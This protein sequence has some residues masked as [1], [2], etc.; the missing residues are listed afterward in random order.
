VECNN[1]CPF[2]VWS[3]YH[4]GCH[5]TNRQL[6]KPKLKGYYSK[7]TNAKYLIGCALFA[8]LLT[9]CSILSMAMQSDD[10]YILAVLSSFLKSVKEIDKL[11]SSSLERWPLYAATL[12]K[13]SE[14]DDTVAYQSQKLKGFLEA[15]R[16]FESMYKAY[17]TK[18]SDCLKSRLSCSDLQM[19]RDIVL[20]LAT[21][22]LDKDDT[23]I[24]LIGLLI[25]FHTL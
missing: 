16:Y 25:I 18:V 7:W 14:T 17:C 15:K 6:T 20:V 22:D 10:F 11:S 12:S 24:P 3:M 21:Q 19:L 4:L 23:L 9:P 8:D 1:T 13:C 2:K 5:R